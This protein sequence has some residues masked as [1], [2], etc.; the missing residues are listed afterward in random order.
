MAILFFNTMTR[1]KEE[2]VPLAPGEVRMYTCEPTVYDF[3]P[4][5]YLRRENGTC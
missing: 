2:F 4:I 5:G 3:A 1:R